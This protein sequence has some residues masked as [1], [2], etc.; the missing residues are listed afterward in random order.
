MLFQFRVFEYKL[1]ILLA[2]PCNKPSSTQKK[3]NTHTQKKMYLKFKN[4]TSLVVQGLRLCFQCRGPR[5]DPW[6]G[7]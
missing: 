2:W 4:G 6:L 3:K 7:N 5:F 1:L